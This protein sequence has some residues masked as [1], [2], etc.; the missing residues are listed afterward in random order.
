MKILVTGGS[1]FIGKPVLKKLIKFDEEIQIMNLSRSQ[2]SDDIEIKDY[3]HWLKCD[4]SDPET[5]IMQVTAFAPDV[6]IHLA[7]EGIPNFS[8][9]QSMK[10]FTASIK[11]LEVVTSLESCK[12]IIVTGSCF[13]YSNKLG[14]CKEIDKAVPKDYFTFAKKSILS[15]LEL[16]SNKRRITYCWA[17]LFYVYG[18]NQR[19]GSLIPMLIDTLKKAK[20]PDLRTP[21]NANDF[22]HVSDVAEGIFNMVT[23]KITSGIY[24]LGSGISTPVTEISNMVELSLL[25][26]SSL[27]SQLIQNTITS[28]KSVDFWAEMEK[29]KKAIDWRPKI[30]LSVGIS[31]LVENQNK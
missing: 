11:L 3:V 13:E 19:S 12:K 15:F 18:P 30:S 23:K 28:E 5:Y 14:A 20:I 16:E 6:V 9:Q 4:L 2:A 17:R 27:T 26:T 1:G 22:I 8:L 31:N 25:K 7:W 21:K 29:T 24:N 10:N